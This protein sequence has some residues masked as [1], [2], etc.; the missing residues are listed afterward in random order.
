MDSEKQRSGTGRLILL[1]ILLGLVLVTSFVALRKFF[2][3]KEVPLPDVIGLD[4]RDAIRVLHLAQLK[5]STY[6][7]SVPKA[8]INQVTSQS[9]FPN[10]VLRP[11]RRVSLGVNT[12]REAFPVPSVVGLDLD[13]AKRV[14][15]VVNMEISEVNYGFSEL[16]IGRIISQVPKAGESLNGLEGLSLNVSRG[17]AQTVVSVPDLRGTTIE[18]A[19]NGLKD[20]G[21]RR[22]ETVP[23]LLS[24]GQAGLVQSQR[25]Q[26]GVEVTTSTPIML[27][28]SLSGDQIVRI[29]SLQG[30]DLRQAEL[31]IRGAGLVL[32]KVNF[33]DE[34]DEP[35]NILLWEPVGHTIVG[36]MVSLVVNRDQRGSTG[37]SIQLGEGIFSKDE[38]N[39]MMS[40]GPIGELYQSYLTQSSSDLIR[41]FI[42]DLLSQ[43]L[44]GYA[45]LLIVALMVERWFRLRLRSLET[46]R[47]KRLLMV[48]FTRLGAPNV[49]ICPPRE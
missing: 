16:P 4:L 33:V 6:P 25:P 44:V 26:A 14:T 3:I 32:G 29:P 17:R 11:G 40:P 1:M 9:P 21:F 39:P 22:I 45:L 47:Y 18:L 28:Y 12:P 13:E 20:I 43:M 35:P 49:L 8:G 30:L 23:S 7:E 10:S 19:V 36:S 41:N 48:G 34:V 2:E 5:V 27:S 46:P 37:N 24:L 38:R 15:I 31:L 42:Y